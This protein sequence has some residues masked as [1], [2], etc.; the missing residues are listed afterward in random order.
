MDAITI[1]LKNDLDCTQGNNNEIQELFKQLTNEIQ[2][3]FDYSNQETMERF[4]TLED[5]ILEKLASS[6]IPGSK[7]AKNTTLFHRTT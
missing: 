7:A 3:R 1:R 2:E 5:L 6:N 4:R